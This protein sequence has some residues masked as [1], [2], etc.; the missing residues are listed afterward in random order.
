MTSKK[1]VVVKSLRRLCACCG[2]NPV[3]IQQASKDAS[4][5]THQRWEMGGFRMRPLRDVLGRA[6]GSLPTPPRAP[7]LL[8]MLAPNLDI[9]CLPLASE[10][11]Q[12][13]LLDLL[14]DCAP[15]GE[16]RPE[17]ELARKPPA[18]LSRLGVAGLALGCRFAAA[19]ARL[20]DVAMERPP[21]APCCLVRL[22]LACA[23][24]FA[25]GRHAF[26]ER[27]SFYGICKSNLIGELS[28]P[29]LKPYGR[30]IRYH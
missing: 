11:C 9:A 7:S 4:K 24:R 2:H 22:A 13:L 18:A 6:P 25:C 26:G 1:T 5:R 10:P 16:A 21:D 27:M 15:F 12:T 19:G 3:I 20:A 14:G 28:C 23:A 17:T 30:A 8:L 29:F